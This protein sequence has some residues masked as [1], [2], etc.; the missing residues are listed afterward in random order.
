MLQKKVCVIT[1]TY[2]PHF[3]NKVQLKEDTSRIRRLHYI[4]QPSFTLH[5]IVIITEKLT[6][7]TAYPRK[8]QNPVLQYSI[9]KNMPKTKTSS[10]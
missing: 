5:C 7:N 2:K 10:Y 3:D 1:M 4:T 6:V 9:R 8:I